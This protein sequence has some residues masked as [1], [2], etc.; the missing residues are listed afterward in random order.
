MLGNAFVG[1]LA[2]LAWGKVSGRGSRGLVAML[3]VSAC[4]GLGLAG[5]GLG[6]GWSF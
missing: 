2:K 3:I 6:S 4:T 5:T 1:A